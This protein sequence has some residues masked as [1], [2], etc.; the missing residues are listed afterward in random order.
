MEDETGKNQKKRPQSQPEGAL[1][2]SK[3]LEKGK[4]MVLMACQGVLTILR[5]PLMG[6]NPF[7]S[8]L[9]LIIPHLG[10]QFNHQFPCAEDASRGQLV[11]LLWVGGRREEGWDRL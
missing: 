6:L 11:P 1:V 8:F 4:G 2:T 7:I 3:A 5:P 9:I 10:T